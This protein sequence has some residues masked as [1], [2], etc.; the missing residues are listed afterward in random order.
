MEDTK[1][2]RA[3]AMALEPVV[4]IGKSGLTDTV[5][6]EIKKQLDQKG[7]I[8]VKILKSFIGREDKKEVA[9]KVAE[10]TN[11]TLV[12]NIGFVVVIAKKN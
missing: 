10:K 4:R 11:S 1:E 8:K 6:A 5:L 2:L 3:K 9:K 7:I 12:Q